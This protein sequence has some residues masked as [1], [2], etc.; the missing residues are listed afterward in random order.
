ML[1][2]NDLMFA[3]QILLTSNNEIKFLVK[4]YS[5]FSSFFN[6]PNFSSKNIGSYSIDLQS[7][8]TPY[9]IPVYD[10]KCKCFY[11]QISVNKAVVIMLCHDLDIPQ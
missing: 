10:F 3:E 5:S 9:L 1:K 4:K 8:S 2:N 7:I 11:T 6:L